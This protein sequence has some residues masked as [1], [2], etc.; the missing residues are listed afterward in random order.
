MDIQEAICSCIRA[1][2]TLGMVRRCTKVSFQYWLPGW[3]RERSV[4]RFKGHE[5][6]VNLFEKPRVVE[7]NRPTMLRLV[8]VVEDSQIMRHFA[9]Q[10][11]TVT[12]P[13]GIYEFPISGVLRWKIERIEDEGF[14]LRVE[15]PPKCFS[16]STVPVPIN[17]IDN[18]QIARAHNVPYLATLG[19]HLALAVNACRHL[20]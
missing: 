8:V 18:M 4:C 5:H 19:K 9:V 15:R 11:V 1:S 16:G 13:C 20:H 7:F 14:T 6:R 10:V 12:S 3:R 2:C 17:D